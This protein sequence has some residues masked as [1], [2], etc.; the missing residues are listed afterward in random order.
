MTSRQQRAEPGNL[1][2]KAAKRR[3]DVI[4][5]VISVLHV[6]LLF[7]HSCPAPPL[8][9]AAPR[10]SSPPADGGHVAG[11]TAAQRQALWDAGG[12]CYPGDGGGPTAADG[13]TEESAA[14]GAEG[15]GGFDGPV[16]ALCC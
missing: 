1:K 9:P 15:E 11:G 7:L 4:H 8:L 16:E 2:P 3:S 10:P 14:A 6:L 5:V 13:Q 12:L